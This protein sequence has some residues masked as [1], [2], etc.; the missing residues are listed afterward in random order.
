VLPLEDGVRCA[1]QRG[2]PLVVAGE[3]A[4]NPFSSWSSAEE[5]GSD[6]AATVETVVA[7]AL[8]HLSA[9]ATGTLRAAIAVRDI[10]EGEARAEVR[11][12]HGGLIAELIHVDQLDRAGVAAAGVRVAGALRATDPWVGSIDVTVRRG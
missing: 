8:P 12:R 6:V 1:A 3:P 7:S 2:L 10:D 11:R 9:V 5:E 4:S